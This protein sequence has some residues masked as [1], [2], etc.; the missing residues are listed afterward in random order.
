MEK[1]N[2]CYENKIHEKHRWLLGRKILS[3]KEINETV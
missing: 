2:E 3:K 1:K